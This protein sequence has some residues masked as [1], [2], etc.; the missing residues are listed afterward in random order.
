MVE[1]SVRRY[2]I[3]VGNLYSAPWGIC[4]IDSVGK[5]TSTWVQWYVTI[6]DRDGVAIPG[7]RRR[8][9]KDWVTSR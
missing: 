1:S 2:G 7:K 8:Q 3:K 9:V 6:V 4:R 5:V